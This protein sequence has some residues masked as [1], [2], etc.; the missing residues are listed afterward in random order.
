MAALDIPA[1]ERS[2]VLIE[3]SCSR[4][5]HNEDSEAAPQCKERPRALLCKA[6]GPAPAAT[7]LPLLLWL[8]SVQH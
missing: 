4:A 7:L 1:P 6:C 3:E 2:E 8:C 5:P